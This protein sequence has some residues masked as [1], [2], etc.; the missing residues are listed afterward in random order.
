MTKT[1]IADLT[2]EMF[3]NAARIR[4]AFGQADS[5]FTELY[6][7]YVEQRS[8]TLHASKLIWNL[9]IAKFALTVVSIDYTVDT[10]QGGALTATA[11]KAAAGATPAAGTTPLHIAAAINL[12]GTIHVTQSIT[13][14][15]TAADLVLAAGE[16]IALVLCGAM[17]VGSGLL[18]I[19]YTRT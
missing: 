3:E 11:V 19:R 10:P 16:K 9:F 18:T 2:G 12:N 7:G 15:V 6:G 13:P 4:T 17:T 1:V 14:T 5:N 8:I